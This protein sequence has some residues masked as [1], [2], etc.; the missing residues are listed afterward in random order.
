LK[1]LAD[2]TLHAIKEKLW[3]EEDGCYMDIEES[4]HISASGRMLTHDVFLYR[5]VVTEN[6]SKIVLDSITIKIN[7]KDR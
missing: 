1:R 4:H 5:V 7:R 6:T 2:K 3:S